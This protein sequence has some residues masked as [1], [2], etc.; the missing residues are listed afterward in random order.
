MHRAHNTLRPPCNVQIF[1]LGSNWRQFASTLP[2]V[3]G[4]WRGS[5][6]QFSDGQQ[7]Q[8]SIRRRTLWMLKI[9]FCLE[10]FS[11]KWG[12]SAPNFAFVYDF[13]FRQEEKFPTAQNLRRGGGHLAPSHPARCHWINQPTN[14]PINQSINQWLNHYQSVNSVDH[15]SSHRPIR[16][17]RE[18]SIT[19]PFLG[20]IKYSVN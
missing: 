15:S 13:F 1:P 6:F 2:Y 11:W 4:P 7:L 9:Q 5:K 20:S 3:V 12:F 16:M 19:L 18:T 17:K 8:T 10:F 14:Q